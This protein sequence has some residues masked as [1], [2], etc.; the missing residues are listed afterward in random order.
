MVGAM[1]HSNSTSPSAAMARVLDR[2]P[3]AKQTASGWQARCPAHKDG[4]ASLSIA[5][6]DD[7][8]NRPASRGTYA[9]LWLHQIRYARRL[10]LHVAYARE[11]RKALRAALGEAVTMI[12]TLSRQRDRARQHANDLRDE[13]RRIVRAKFTGEMRPPVTGTVTTKPCGAEAVQ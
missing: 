5:A 7:D 1:P 10:R 4:R 11:Q 2:L 9:A 12:G 8:S 3:D 13:N 6:G